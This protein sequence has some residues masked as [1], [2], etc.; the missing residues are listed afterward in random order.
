MGPTFQDLLD[1]L[2]R[3]AAGRIAEGELTERAL[4]R[5]AGISQPHLHNVLKGVRSLTPGVAD[6]LMVSL[7]LTLADLSAQAAT[8]HQMPMMGREHSAH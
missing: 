4:A 1:S 8:A 5:R 2:R 3:R 7:S 6:R